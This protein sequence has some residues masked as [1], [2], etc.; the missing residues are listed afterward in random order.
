MCSRNL[1]TGPKTVM[2]GGAIPA[3]F[4]RS[5]M[6]ARVPTTTFWRGVAPHWIIAAGVSGGF[7]ASRSRRT[8]RGIFPTP[9]TT[10]RVSTRAR[11]FQ[12]CSCSVPSRN[13]CPVAMTALPAI[14]RC[15]MGIP[16]YS[17][18][19]MGD[20]IPG[21]NSKGT[22]AAS[23]ASPSSPPRPKTNGSPP[24][25]RTTRFPSLP[26]RTS[27]SLISSWDAL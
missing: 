10:T 4:P 7:P 5:T 19:A 17:S 8:M 21:T 23:S 6:S 15:V 9:I 13:R 18:A 26:S 24:F 11:A 20:V 12:S 3:A 16:A 14:S 25:S 2:A 27:M 22:P 1:T